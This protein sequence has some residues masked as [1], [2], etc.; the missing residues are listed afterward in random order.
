[1]CTLF[2]D[3]Q[4]RTSACLL[5]LVQVLLSGQFVN[6]TDVPDAVKDAFNLG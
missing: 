4:C 1:V 5:L 2:N 6:F 3:A